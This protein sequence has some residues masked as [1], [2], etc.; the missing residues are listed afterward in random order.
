MGI[1]KEV[2]GDIGFV[3]GLKWGTP[4]G[5]VY[6]YDMSYSKCNGQQF[7]FVTSVGSIRGDV[8]SWLVMG[9]RLP[10]SDGRTRWGVA[11]E[12]ESLS[13]GSTDSRKLR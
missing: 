13:R 2:A 6:I 5:W 12:F 11:T 10:G 7:L 1:A 8:S 4:P 9:P 3:K